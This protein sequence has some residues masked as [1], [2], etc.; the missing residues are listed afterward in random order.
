VRSESGQASVEMVAVV[1]LVVLVGAVAWQLALAGQAVWL[2]ANAARVAAR[3]EA[4]GEDR[5]RAARSALPGSFE[6][7]LSVDA[8]RRGAVR[9]R[10]RIPL[11]VR[12]WRG[13]VTV[14]ASAALPQGQPVRSRGQASVELVGAVPAILLT[15][16]VV[17]QLLALGYSKVLAGNA[18]EAAA[19]AAASGGEPRA[20]AR[21]AVPRWS[22]ARMRV[23]SRAGRIVVRMRPP[24]L[25]RA[26]GRALE[27]EATAA[28][29][30]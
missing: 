13:P 27:V 26:L 9:V 10:L 21:A 20:A 11:I 29:N 7:G 18:A 8:D 1:P 15:G 23:Q 28:V 12:R 3:A 2:C 5:E 4:V 30:P 6:R 22:R 14:S 19:I 16:L 24:A 25:L 17:F